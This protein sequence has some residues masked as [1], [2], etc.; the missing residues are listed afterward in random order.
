[1]LRRISLYGCADVSP[2]IWSNMHALSH[3]VEVFISN[4]HQVPQAFSL[5]RNKWGAFLWLLLILVCVWVFFS[6]FVF[7]GPFLFYFLLFSFFKLTNWKS[8]GFW[9]IIREQTNR[10]ENHFGGPWNA[11]RY[12][13]SVAH[14]PRHQQKRLFTINMMMD[15]I[16]LQLWLQSCWVCG[17][18][19]IACLNTIG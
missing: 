3:F 4:T 10:P 9:G 6:K 16:A 13:P 17:L 11:D 8:S 18:F 19:V 7:Q 14:I 2:S 15:S 1:M 5:N 12:C